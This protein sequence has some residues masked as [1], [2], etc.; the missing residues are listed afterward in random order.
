MAKR[1]VNKSQMVRDYLQANPEAKANDV[2]AALAEKGHKITANLVYYLKGKSAAKKERKKRV[3]RAAKATS[4]NGT[5][6][7]DAISMIRDVRALAERAGGYEK[8]K[9]LVDA[10]AG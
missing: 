8:L 1:K 4:S 7:T 9:E 5:G 6:G 10:L 3:L 2:V